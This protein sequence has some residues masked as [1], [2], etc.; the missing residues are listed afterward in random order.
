[1]ANEVVDRMCI[2]SGEEETVESIR[3]KRPLAAAA[4]IFC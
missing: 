2:G 3:G 4:E 1:M